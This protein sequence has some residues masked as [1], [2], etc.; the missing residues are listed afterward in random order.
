MCAKRCMVPARMPKKKSKSVPPSPEFSA[1]YARAVG[2]GKPFRNLLS[3]S[4][5]AGVTHSSVWRALNAGSQLTP[6]NLAKLAA[7]VPCE[8]V[9][10][11]A[12]VITEHVQ[13]VQP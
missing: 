13:E 2:A 6:A 4:Q 11:P 9:A 12:P 7:V 5:C 3:W 10:E 8:V 1:L